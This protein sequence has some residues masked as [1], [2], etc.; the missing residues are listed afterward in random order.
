MSLLRLQADLQQLW[1]CFDI[2][3]T[4]VTVAYPRFAS[5]Y[6]PDFRHGPFNTCSGPEDRLVIV[7]PGLW[8]ITGSA[9]GRSG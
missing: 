7:L 2:A 5:F 6:L 8:G 9:K 1:D 4:L 3:K